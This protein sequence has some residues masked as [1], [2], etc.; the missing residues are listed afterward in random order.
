MKGKNNIAG[1]VNTGVHPVYS[2]K[3]SKEEFYPNDT[4]IWSRKTNRKIGGSKQQRSG[5]LNTGR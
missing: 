1:S 5:P 4:E 3:F 2:S